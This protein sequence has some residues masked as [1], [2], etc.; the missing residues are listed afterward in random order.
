VPDIVRVLRIVEYV[1]PRDWVE[2][3]VAG[4]INGTRVIAAD[5]HI[6]AAT[7]GAF[8]EILKKEEANAEDHHC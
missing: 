6:S 4:S 1:G 8:P 2:Q 7:I 5:R 3:T